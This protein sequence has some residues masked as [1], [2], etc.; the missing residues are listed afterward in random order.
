MQY[1]QFHHKIDLPKINEND[2]DNKSLYVIFFFT[3]IHDCSNL[4][5]DIVNVFNNYYID[6]C[7]KFS[8]IPETATQWQQVIYHLFSLIKNN[9]SN[10]TFELIKMEIKISDSICIS[11]SD[12][13]YI[14]RNN[15]KIQKFWLNKKINSQL[16]IDTQKYYDNNQNNNKKRVVDIIKGLFVE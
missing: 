2:S 7:K 8:I 6:T 15:V 13:I 10:Y 9:F 11:T 4:D 14:G 3:N 12:D 1:Y 16:N 5:L